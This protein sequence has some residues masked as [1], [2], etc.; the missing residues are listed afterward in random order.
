MDRNPGKNKEKSVL[1]SPFLRF[2]KTTDFLLKFSVFRAGVLKWLPSYGTDSVKSWLGFW[3]QMR[4]LA[5][6]CQILLER[7]WVC[8]KTSDL[9]AWKCSGKQ[10][11]HKDLTFWVRRPPGQ[12]GVFHA[13]GWWP[14]VRAL[15]RKFVFFGVR[16]EESGMSREFCRDVPDPG[17]F[18]KFVQ[19]KFVLIFRC[20]EFFLEL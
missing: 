5:W 11:E 3:L 15:P 20:L 1:V 14:K 9:V 16:R 7:A 6:N 19:K 4:A 12:V 10:K 8:L 17:R 18:K 2:T 13:K